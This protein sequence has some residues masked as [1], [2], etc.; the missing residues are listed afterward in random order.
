MAKQDPKQTNEFLLGQ[1]ATDVATIK[2]RQVE[3]QVEQKDF[4]TEIHAQQKEF[5][6]FVEKKI[7]AI[8]LEVDEIKETNT[9][10]R[11]FI[12]AIAAVGGS[13]GVGITYLGKFILGIAN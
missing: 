11:G 10:N 9:F 12:A 3:I 1:I 5:R 8:Q 4:R 6:E 2:A 7:N 13:L